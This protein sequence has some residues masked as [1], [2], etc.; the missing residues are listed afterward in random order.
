[1]SKRE[2]TDFVYVMHTKTSKKVVAKACIATGMCRFLNVDL[3]S[4][5]EC[6]GIHYRIPMS[7]GPMTPGNEGNIKSNLISVTNKA[8]ALE[9]RERRNHLQCL[10]VKPLESTA[11]RSLA[12]YD[13]D[14]GIQTGMSDLSSIYS[15]QKRHAYWLSSDERPTKSGMLLLRSDRKIVI[16]NAMKQIFVALMRKSLKECYRHYTKQ[17]DSL[18]VAYRLPVSI[19]TQGD[20]APSKTK[21]SSNHVREC[22]MAAHDGG[23]SCESCLQSHIGNSQIFSTISHLVAVQPADTSKLGNCIIPG[24]NRSAEG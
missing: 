19:G 16:D 18:P 20:V 21:F 9:I 14:A 17:F 3:I 6:E 2:L 4:E 7:F 24:S 13:I 22:V 5:D 1:M 15:V 23:V 12:L 8:I 11:S 10:Y